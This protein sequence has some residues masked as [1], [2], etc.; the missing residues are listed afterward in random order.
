MLSLLTSL[1]IVLIPLV[2]LVVTA[3]VV[4]TCRMAAR[5][6]GRDARSAR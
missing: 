6:D 5:G 2:W 1:L 3:M 4:T